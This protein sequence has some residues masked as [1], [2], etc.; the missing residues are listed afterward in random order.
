[1]SEGQTNVVEQKVDLAVAGSVGPDAFG[2]GEVSPE[3]L[4]T[5]AA[6]QN[7]GAAAS[8]VIDVD[9]P[10]TITEAKA[11]LKA[12]KNGISKAE[13]IEFSLRTNCLNFK[14]R[15][16]WKSLGYNSLNA[17]IKKSLV[18]GRAHFYRLLDAASTVEQLEGGLG[19]S[20]KA[21][22]VQTGDRAL[23]V[24]KSLPMSNEDKVK[25]YEEASS[26]AAKK[27]QKAPDAG[28]I[29]AAEKKLVAANEVTVTKAE[30]TPPISQPSDAASSVDQ[31]RIE[32]E[33]LQRSIGSLDP[34]GDVF[35]HSEM[36][37]SIEKIL[38]LLL[39]WGG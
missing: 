29:R 3:S 14:R 8:D 2:S 27:K 37:K 28:H 6:P 25:V 4:P 31:V 20:A 17:C 33:K 36:A 35:A 21:H 26:D 23:N 7:D 11:S 5:G 30:K 10:M 38:S 24:V 12:I 34:A 18:V 15:N 13:S 16:G 9:N 1:M 22:L 32:A 19:D 39:T